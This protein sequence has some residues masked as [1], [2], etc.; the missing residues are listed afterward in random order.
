MSEYRFV[1]VANMLGSRREEV[2]CEPVIDFT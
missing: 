2:G 1:G